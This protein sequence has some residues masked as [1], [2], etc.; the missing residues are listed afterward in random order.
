MELVQELK[1]SLNLEKKNKTKVYKECSK[2]KPKEID[3]W[4]QAEE[5][6]KRYTDQLRK[7]SE[8]YAE[9]KQSKRK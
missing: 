1:T 8:Q 6:M 9:Q 7:E 4:A 3:H 5:A 2:C